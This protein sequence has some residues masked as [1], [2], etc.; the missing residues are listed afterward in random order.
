M[1]P[2]RN[3]LQAELN[4]ALRNRQEIR[5]STLRMV[6]AAIRNAEIEVRHDLDDDGIVVVLQKQ[7]KQR[8]ESIEEFR[9]ANRQDLVDKESAEL[10]TIEEFLPAQVDREAIEVAAR[11]VIAETGAAS[12]RDLGKVMPVLTREFAGRADGRLINEVVRGLLS[13]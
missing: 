3:R 8:R 5:K 2:L 11:R 7:A 10:A 9:K 6:L 13:S 4:E 1:S 12:V